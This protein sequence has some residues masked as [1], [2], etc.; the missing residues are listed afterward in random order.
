[1]NKFE[2]SRVGKL[3]FA[4]YITNRRQAIKGA[5][6]AI[7]ALVMLNLIGLIASEGEM[8]YGDNY[9]NFEG[10]IALVLFIVSLRTFTK[11]SDKRQVNTHFMIPATVGEK[12]CSKLIQ[13]LIFMP[14]YLYA[15][16]L[17]VGVILFLL[18]A[19][20]PGWS[21]G[22]SPMIDEITL[23]NILSVLFV[24]SITL[25]CSAVYRKPFWM[26]V[27]YFAVWGLISMAYLAS[28]FW[29]E[30]GED[31]MSHINSSLLSEY[32]NS[33][34]YSSD[35]SSH[36]MEDSPI[37]FFVSRTFF[38]IVETFI[39]IGFFVATFVALKRRQVE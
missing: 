29:V 32:E 34:Y 13:I 11:F 22:V 2:I 31:V 33:Y 39:T 4:D 14:I 9:Q 20:I 12:Y 30:Y 37:G 24:L 1:M 3:I 8:T 36:S 26:S 16:Y 10:V 21:I 25:F 35:F 17:A 15:I 38:T 18:A 27:L 23:H 28:I 7:L 19:I 5:L 6:I